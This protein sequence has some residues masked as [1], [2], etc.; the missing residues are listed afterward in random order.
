MLDKSVVFVSRRI[1]LETHPRKR[2]EALDCGKEKKR[3][4]VTDTPDTRYSYGVICFA[5]PRMTTAI[6]SVIIRYVQPLSYAHREA[7]K[8]KISDGKRKYHSKEA[9][10][11]KSLTNNKFLSAG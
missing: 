1:R 8:N 3:L 6:S 11:K 2:K 5:R 10:V 9:K 7:I 4:I